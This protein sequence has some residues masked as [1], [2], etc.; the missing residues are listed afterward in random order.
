MSKSRKSWGPR[1]D[2]LSQQCALLHGVCGNQTQ[3]DAM[4][5]LQMLFNSCYEF[6]ISPLTQI[7]RCFPA[8]EWEYLELGVAR[9]E[10]RVLATK[11][12]FVWRVRL[13]GIVFASRKDGMKTGQI[14]CF[15]DGE[16]K[17]VPREVF[18]SL[19]LS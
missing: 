14:I 4:N 15:R 6:G 13:G 11:S 2:T 16:L 12:D 18:C 5:D 3:W 8:L 10:N 9:H 19:G 17:D 7:R 1:E